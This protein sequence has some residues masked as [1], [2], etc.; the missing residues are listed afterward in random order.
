MNRAFG[1][2]LIAAALAAGCGSGGTPDGSNGSDASSDAQ[3]AACVDGFLALTPGASDNCYHATTCDGGPFCPAV[4]RNDPNTP[5][6]RITQIDARRP[7]ALANP[8]L[9][10]TLNSAVAGG[11]FGWGIVLDFSAMSISTGAL[12]QGVSAQPGTGIL[13]AHFDFYHGDADPTGGPSDRWDP[14]TANIV[15]GNLSFS[16]S[17]VSLVTVPA[18]SPQTGL[19]FTEF[20]IHNASVHDVQLTSG[21]DCIGWAKGQGF[22]SCSPSQWITRSDP[23]GANSA[24][25]LEGDISV[26]DARNVTVLNVGPLC[27]VLSGT[28]NCM[29]EPETWHNPPDVRVDR[30]PV[31]TGAPAD[32]WHL[33]ADFAAVSADIGT[34][35]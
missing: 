7:A 17:T 18:Y 21:L 3:D 22:N 35:P 23:T 27:D 31:G 15:L 25:V 32:A 24:G 1:L 2:G 9:S 20:P 19:L 29:G 4:V 8:I 30:M 28:M 11:T 33:V 12:R 14:V 13:G 26:A 10:F 34:S 6:F 16:S 5:K